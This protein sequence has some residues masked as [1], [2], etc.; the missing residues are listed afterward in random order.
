MVELQDHF[1]AFGL[2]HNQERGQES[3]VWWLT[4]FFRIRSN[5]TACRSACGFS[6]GK[7]QDQVVWQFNIQRL[8][9][10][11]CSSRLRH[12]QCGCQQRWPTISS[13][14]CGKT[15]W[16]SKHV[17]KPTLCTRDWPSDIS[18]HTSSST[19]EHRRSAISSSRIHVCWITPV[20]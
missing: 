14:F 7:D 8:L 18:T 2:R 3:E 10:S 12:R 11:A 1:S 20:L 16:R 4:V 9:G 5:S 19:H 15:L 6:I 13:A 17:R